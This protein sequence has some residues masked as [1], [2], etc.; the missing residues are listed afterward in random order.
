M[1]P[2]EFLVEENQEQPSSQGEAGPSDAQR[3]SSSV[4]QSP[5]KTPLPFLNDQFNTDYYQLQDQ[6]EELVN[7]VVPTDELTT[8]RIAMALLLVLLVVPGLFV[9]LWI[10]PSHPFRFL[11]AIF[12]M[13][14][15]SL[16]VGFVYFVQQ[17]VLRP[18]RRVLPM[19]DHWASVLHQEALLFCEDW[20]QEQ[21]WLL[22][23]DDNIAQEHHSQ[24][25]AE[26]QKKSR[27]KAK[28]RVFAIFQP[29]MPLFVRR[30]RKNTESQQGDGIYKETGEV[31]LSKSPP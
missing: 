9:T 3:M 12:W 6:A 22:L 7:Q 15:A 23:V 31:E 20:Q 10:F 14:L 2:S 11:L 29:M 24:H 4:Q 27:R 26:H 28:S 21:N 18:D 17:D 16:F 30:R 25:Q 8:M 13:I 1:E 5:S 19:V